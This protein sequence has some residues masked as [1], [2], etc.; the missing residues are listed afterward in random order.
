MKKKKDGGRNRGREKGGRKKEK[1]N[2]SSRKG[3]EGG[4]E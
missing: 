3:Q 1:G 4:N 2:M